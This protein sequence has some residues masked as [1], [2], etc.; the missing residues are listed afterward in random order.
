MEEATEID[1][2]QADILHAVRCILDVRDELGRKPKAK[3]VHLFESLAGA[4]YGCC[5]ALKNL[6]EWST[7]EEILAF[8]EELQK[9]QP[10]EPS[11]RFKEVFDEPL[12]GLPDKRGRVTKLNGKPLTKG[13]LTG[14]QLGDMRRLFRYRADQRGKQPTQNEID[15]ALWQTLEKEELPEMY[16][17]K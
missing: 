13:L 5:E 1:K 16:R 6:G 4:L 10:L 11:P 7:S 12:V 3:H 8:V 17:P 9:E 14:F 2:A 15:D